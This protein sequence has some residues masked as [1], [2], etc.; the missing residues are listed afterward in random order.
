MTEYAGN[1]KFLHPIEVILTAPANRPVLTAQSH[2]M[3]TEILA[4]LTYLYGQEKGC[5]GLLELWKKVKLP[6]E[7]DFVSS[8][9]TC[10]AETGYPAPCESSDLCRNASRE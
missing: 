6:Q 9:I 7:S 2:K 5:E 4:D 1:K 8:I 10:F 3:L